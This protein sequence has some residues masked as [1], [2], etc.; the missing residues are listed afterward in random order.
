MGG[1]CVQ[2][3]L[4]QS[5]IYIENNY[6]EIVEQLPD[7]VSFCVSC[8][9]GMQDE[10]NLCPSCGTPR[11]VSHTPTN[12]QM[13]IV[14]P[15]KS[16]SDA[17]VVIA[18]IGVL[19][20]V[21]IATVFFAN[22]ILGSGNSVTDLVSDWDGDGISDANDPDDDNDGYN[23]ENDWYDQ[24]NGGLKIKFTK[25]EIWSEGNY[26]SDGNPDVY[27]YVGIGDGNCEGMQYF[28]YLDDINEDASI[29]NN[30]EEY[31]TNIDDDQNTACVSVTIYDEDS[32]A[33]DDILDFVPGNAN[34]Y[35][36]PFVLSAGEGDILVSEDNRG[37]NEL[38][39]LVEYE[40]SR[41]AVVM[42]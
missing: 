40:I 14:M 27:A 19:V 28:E 12:P 31:I 26:D 13:T 15:E 6:L 16:G 41:I 2:P 4:S 24:G 35:N 42:D 5:I 21:I 29:L 32:W 3:V 33:P 8:G 30:W 25:F 9:N 37:E 36:H 34:Y 20:I 1:P 17:G 18:A 10:W 38:S 11:S 23:D 7:I 39:I 22:S